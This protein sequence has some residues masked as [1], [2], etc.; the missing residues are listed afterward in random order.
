MLRQ[1]IL[2]GFILVLLAAGFWFLFPSKPAGDGKLTSLD[3]VSRDA[4]FVWENV[5]FPHT[6]DRIAHHSVIWEELKKIEAVNEL[7][8]IMHECD[9]ALRAHSDLSALTGSFNA[10]FA[11]EP[12]KKS[13]VPVWI[14]NAGEGVSSRTF[15]NNIEAA[16]NA[17][18]TDDDNLEIKL[19]KHTLYA[20]FQQNLVVVCTDRNVAK[21]A[22]DR[23]NTDDA[24]TADSTFQRL[25][26][27]TGKVN[28]GHVFINTPKLLSILMTENQP[29]S[30]L[31]N[32]LGGR[33]A[34]DVG[35]KSNIWILNGFVN[36]GRYGDDFLSL[37]QNQKPTARSL[38]AV[39]P[40][41]TESF[42]HLGFSHFEEWNRG[43]AEYLQN[44]D[45]KTLYG[46]HTTES[47][48][49][50]T[51]WIE[52]EIAVG[53]RN[54]PALG[55]KEGFYAIIKTAN[56]N[57][58][59]KQLRQS[60][61]E[62]EEEKYADFTLQKLRHDKLL[63]AALGSLFHQFH[64]AHYTIIDR[65]IVFA[66]SK[67]SLRRIIN[68]YLSGKTLRND[69]GYMKFDKSLSA[70]SNVLFF[71]RPG[72]AATALPDLLNE[73]THNLI[74]RYDSTLKNF[75]GLALQWSVE[76][77][78]LFYHSIIL[79]H[80]PE[81]KTY[82]H[83]L[84]ELALDSGLR[85]APKVVINHNSGAKE[86]FVQTLKNTVYLISNTGKI[87][88]SAPVEGPIMSDI[89]QI[90]RYDNNKLQLLFNTREKLYLIDRLG[91]SVTAY[92]I[93]F[94]R[95]A[96]SGINVVDYD[97][98]GDLRIFV[99]LENGDLLNFNKKGTK[100]KGWKYD[101]PRSP[102]LTPPEHVSIKGKDYLI[103][104]LQNGNVTALNRRGEERLSLSEKLPLTPKP[105]L[106]LQ[107]GS[108]KSLTKLYTIDTNGVLFELNLN[109]E[110]SKTV[111]QSTRGDSRFL[112]SPIF[113]SE[114]PEFYISDSTGIYGY[115]TN[116]ELFLRFETH[117]TATARLNPVKH[118]A[119]RALSAVYPAENQVWLMNNTGTPLPDFPMRG[120]TGPT[121]DNLND[122]QTLN[123]IVSDAAGVLYNYVIHK[124]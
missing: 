92:P 46:S 124:P 59:A 73:S 61:D 50:I 71:V 4:I 113:N 123:L 70:E 42:V 89:F 116:K 13:F 5:D 33:S 26:N 81:K 110:L 19:G 34:L 39:M 51:S 111:L 25:Y 10:C 105:M 82:A 86:L 93:S 40:E 36:T 63:P 31:L 12:L 117:D 98:N 78:N 67:E 120:H 38:L 58:A 88:W 22:L 16:L 87:L 47:K 8:D 97:N 108:D 65:Y 96:S 43:Y 49:T 27:T 55:E 72:Y 21:K 94:E 68:D 57:T 1:I 80:N 37:F 69:E 18:R 107:R 76:S 99:G 118:E 109:D 79:K 85:T 75:S 83:S 20:H 103:T 64:T 56:E 77:N 7:N 101:N 90:D 15:I 106:Y 114:Q 24:V 95:P 102:A 17:K 3:A 35:L 53:F 60:S 104:L 119:V 54:D 6:F 52:S 44:T 30:N 84:W 122:D 2:Y 74:K 9:T 66:A 11:V 91:N 48:A 45:L 28:H 41:N 32:E 23:L 100:V 14:F 115:N 121:V 62:N 29:Q 112:I